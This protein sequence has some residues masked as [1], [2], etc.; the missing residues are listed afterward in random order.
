MESDY[1]SMPETMVE[2]QSRVGRRV[3]KP[4]RFDQGE[5]LEESVA[6]NGGMWHHT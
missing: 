6:E 5:M 3:R 4:G 2:S 1:E